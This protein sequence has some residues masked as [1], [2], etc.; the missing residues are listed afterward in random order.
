VFYNNP[1]EGGYPYIED[2]SCRLM[3]RA[4]TITQQMKLTK[5]LK[6]E[7]TSILA[8]PLFAFF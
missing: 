6:E 8:M 3:R 7:E 4:I 1:E 2:I 5:T